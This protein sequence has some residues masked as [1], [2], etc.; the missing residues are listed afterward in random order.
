MRR[1]ARRAWKG[2]L[3]HMLSSATKGPGVLPK[4]CMPSS[5]YWCAAVGTCQAHAQGRARGVAARGRAVA[6]PRV[7]LLELDRAG[8]AA[9]VSDRRRG[10]PRGRPA[11]LAAAPSGAAAGAPKTGRRDWPSRDRAVAGCSAILQA[12]RAAGATR[13]DAARGRGRECRSSQSNPRRAA[14]AARGVRHA[15]QGDNLRGAALSARV[16]RG[17]RAR[18]GLRG[19]A[20]RASAPAP[21]SGPCGAG[22]S[23]TSWC[24]SWR[25]SS[26]SSRSAQACRSSRCAPT[27]RRTRRA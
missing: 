20:G 25:S 15:A 16:A 6:V 19:A 12:L 23:R 1:R 9:A 11:A 27:A 22:T 18:L 8:G 24:S 13:H 10:G 3:G 21:P 17:G 4:S 5:Q 2:S 14:R 7:R 26:S